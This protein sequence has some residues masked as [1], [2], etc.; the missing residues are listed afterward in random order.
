MRFGVGEGGGG[1]AGFGWVGGVG[2]GE[3][4]GGEGVVGRLEEVLGEARRLIVGGFVWGGGAR[5]VRRGWGGC[6]SGRL[7]GGGVLVCCV[8][9][10]L[11]GCCCFGV[12]RS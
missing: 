2:G 4:K 11:L 8:V 6:G 5:G 3:R 1:I 9:W 7:M 10:V 12:V